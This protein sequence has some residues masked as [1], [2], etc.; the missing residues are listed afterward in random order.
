[1]NPFRVRTPQTASRR[2]WM[3]SVAA[4]AGACVAGLQPVPH[5]HAA[6]PPSVP[7]GLE[8]PAGHKLLR[9][10]HAVGTQN[11][12]CLPASDPTA[13]PPFVWAQLGPQATLFNAHLRQTMTH[14]LSANADE[15]GT[16]RPTWQDS[17]DSSAIWGEPIASS[18]DPAFVESGAVAWLLLEVVGRDDGPT[19]G[20][21]ISRATYL[22]RVNTSGGKAPATGCSESGHVGAK[23]LVP[24]AADYVFYRSIGPLE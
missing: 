1:M 16:F 11:Y 2:W 7:L 14:Y 23:A 3:T 13:D 22:Q 17:R 5:A 12:V 15:G 9:M 18:S 19:G 10:E 6:A 21:K 4:L 24:Y 8:V 20:H